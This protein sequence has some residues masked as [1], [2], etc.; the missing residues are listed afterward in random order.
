MAVEVSTL[1]GELDESSVLFA[2]NGASLWFKY[3]PNDSITS[4]SLSSLLS[5]PASQC[6]KQNAVS[7]RGRSPYASPCL[8]QF[9][10]LRFCPCLPR[11]GTIVYR[12][13]CSSAMMQSRNFVVIVRH[14]QGSWSRFRLLRCGPVVGEDRVSHG[15]HKCWIVWLV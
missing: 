1:I 3:S 15:T 13:L 7:T 11:R 8:R 14:T 4:T 12:T 10:W 9:L 5:K 6:G 2:R